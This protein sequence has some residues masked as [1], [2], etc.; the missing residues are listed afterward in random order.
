MEEE[1]SR[2]GVMPEPVV[3][4]GPLVVL[5]AGVVEE[6][7][8]RVGELGAGVVAGA[9]VVEGCTEAGVVGST[10]EVKRLEAG[11]LPQMQTQA[12]AALVVV[13]GPAV[14]EDSR[15]GV[16]DDPAAVVA[17]E[18]IVVVVAVPAGVVEDS[19]TGE[20]VAGP[21]VVVEVPRG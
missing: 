7:G 19:C 9:A 5:G 11:G 4:R 3:S 18:N 8:S 15:W 16:S 17:V 1:V 10:E 6:P 14:V 13:L 21:A 2:K 12:G 20:E